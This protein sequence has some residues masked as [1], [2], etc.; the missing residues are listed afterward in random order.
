[1][2]DGLTVGSPPNGN[3]AASYVVDAG[4]ADEV[5]FTTASG[6]G[7]N[8]TAGL[9]MNIVGKSGGNAHHGSFF[10]SGSREQFQSD[11]LTPELRAEARPPRRRCRRSTTC[12]GRSVAHWSA[13]DLVLRQRAHRRQHEGQQQRVLQPERR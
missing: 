8:E 5:T 13:T 10:V 11:N 4:E 12:P 3:S 2:L 1:M 7:E 9:V 6:L